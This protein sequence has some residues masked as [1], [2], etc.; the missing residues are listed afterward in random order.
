MFW[1]CAKALDP[2]KSNAAKSIHDV[3]V[4]KSR[5]ASRLRFNSVMQ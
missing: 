2:R 4:D 5:C 3:A 1:F